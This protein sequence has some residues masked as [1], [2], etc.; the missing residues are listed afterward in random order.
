MSWKK[1]NIT[2]ETV[3]AMLTA[4]NLTPG[5]CETLGTAMQTLMT[6]FEEDEKNLVREHRQAYKELLLECRA[7]LQEISADVNNAG[8][9]TKVL[10]LQY[11]EIIERKLR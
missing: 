4:S 3:A 5:I 8:M 11:Q 7:L 6:A 2:N 9:G 1:Y 10:A